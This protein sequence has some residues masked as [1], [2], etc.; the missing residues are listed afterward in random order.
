M[1]TATQTDLARCASCG[2]T[3]AVPPVAQC[4]TCESRQLRPALTPTM[5][6]ID[7]LVAFAEE[8]GGSLSGEKR[9]RLERL[10]LTLYAIGRGDAILARSEGSGS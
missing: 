5:K 6:A 7:E 2:W 1:A 10:C 3:G 9:E 8:H 4:P